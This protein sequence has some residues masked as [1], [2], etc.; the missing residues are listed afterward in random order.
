MDGFSYWV[1]RIFAGVAGLTT[2]QKIGILFSIVALFAMAFSYRL[3]NEVKPG[4]CEPTGFPARCYYIRPKMCDFEWQRSKPP[5]EDFVKKQNLP[6]GRLLG[7]IIF[8]CQLAHLDEAFGNRRK[9]NPECDEMYSKLKSWR[10]R[11]GY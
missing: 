11:N 7:P 6:P 10:Q 4:P 9:S 2:A 3:I 8:Y 1:N 5:C